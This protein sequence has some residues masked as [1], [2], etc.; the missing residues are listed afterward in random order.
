MSESLRYLQTQPLKP[1]LYLRYIDDIFLIW[2]HGE[3]SLK[4]FHQ[5]LNEFHPTIKLTL[6][7][8]EQQVNFLD[9]TV[10]ISNGHLTTSIYKKP[11][12]RASYLHGS[13]SHPPHTTRS[14]VYSQALRYN[15][16][17]SDTMDCDKRTPQ[18][19]PSVLSRPEVQP[20]HCS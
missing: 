3:E 18:Q 17:C 12:D 9:T 14:I 8:S 19:P 1:L 20:P 4:Q 15:C 13:S 6:E 7:H 10:S 2:L 11:T 16:I 5:N